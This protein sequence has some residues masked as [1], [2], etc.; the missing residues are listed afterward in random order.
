MIQI[1]KNPASSKNSATFPCLGRPGHRVSQWFELSI[2]GWHAVPSEQNEAG[3]TGCCKWHYSL[4]EGKGLT[5]FSFDFL[6]PST[7]PKLTTQYIWHS[8]R[9]LNNSLMKWD[10]RDT[11]IPLNLKPTTQSILYYWWHL[12][13]CFKKE[14]NLSPSTTNKGTKQNQPPSPNQRECGTV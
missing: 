7:M 8:K 13:A 14:T 10:L 5:Q 6:E 4:L 9:Q 1:H 3:K 12:R 2:H 11:H